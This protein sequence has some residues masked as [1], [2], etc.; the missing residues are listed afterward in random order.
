MRQSTCTTRL[1]LLFITI[2]LF[3]GTIA[4]KEPDEWVLEE[5]RIEAEPESSLTTEPETVVS[6]P[7]P[8][9][10]SNDPIRP[11]FG[12][13]NS[14]DGTLKEDQEI[15][16]PLF[17]LEALDRL[18]EPYFDFKAGVQEDYGLSFGTDYTA[19][20]GWANKSLGTHDAAGGIVRFFGDW[21][22]FGEESGNTGS[23][24]FKVENRHRIGT[25]ISPNN[26]G[27]E[28]GYNGLPAPIYSDYSW[29]LTNF[30][31]R[32]RLFG[33][34]ASLVV[35]M[36]DVTDYLDVYGM[37]NPWTSFSNLAFLTNP[38]I[39]APN[40]GFG[41]AAAGMI[42]DNIYMIAGFSDANGTPTNIG[43]NFTTFFNQGEYFKHIELGWTSAQ[44]KLYLDNVHITGWQVDR[45]AKTETPSGW[46]ISVSAATF[47]DEKWMPFLRAGYS[48]DGG[49]L[50][51]G[52]VS[53]G[54]GYRT[55]S[56]DLVGLG[57]NWSRPAN[58]DPEVDLKDQYTVEL[59][60]R[61]QL[62]ENLAIT[63]DIQLI[64]NPAQH[65]EANQIWVLGLRGRLAL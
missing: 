14:V 52:S 21:T 4:A 28:V 30:Y 43:D 35:G 64:L 31:W 27:F 39:P 24:V 48:K 36:V 55:N 54:L 18:L 50:W 13:P 57:L 29:G 59:F 49:A 9:S 42:T 3:S 2:S 15:K 10:D 37:V 60:Y 47:L 1:F 11:D 61:F 25:R 58:S 20:Y 62:S 51:Q 53:T 32:Q 23:L 8:I 17:R 33:G 45:R 16:E 38:T 65:P 26:L 40:Q 6:D 63:P 19:Y 44:D 34:R 56:S 7:P 22:L 5:Q 12:G 41:A 46:G